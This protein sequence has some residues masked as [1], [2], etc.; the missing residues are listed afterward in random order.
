MTS[1]V[2]EQPTTTPPT[3]TG[4][5][6]GA[7]SDDVDLFCPGC[8]YHLRGIE[9]ID[10][11]PEC[12]L[13]I[14]RA[15]V[16][17]SLVPWAHRRHIGRFRAY[18]RTVWLATLHPRKLAA[19][20]AR[21]VEYRDA[22]RFRYVTAVL[23]AA[24][25]VVGM[26]VAM[27]AYGGSGFFSVVAPSAIPGWAMYGPPSPAVDVLVPWESGMTFYPVAPLA[28]LL[29]C[30][31]VTGV[32]TYWFHPKRL[33]VVR[34][35]RAIALAYYGCAPLALSPVPA[36]LFAAVAG[37]GI[38]G[39]NDPANAS[40]AVVRILSIALVLSTLAVVVL[41]WRTMMTLLN[42][43][44]QPGLGRLLLAGALIPFEWLVCAALALV[45]FPWVLGFFRLVIHSLR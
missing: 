16:A 32:H 6:D 18:W 24:P 42:R 15:G 19:E 33:P 17:R 26:V 2:D 12:G 1:T 22:R 37:M 38:A 31:L 40:W 44:T 11:C 23:A 14:D 29:L 45:A 30:V 5:S 10:R 35:N 13:A 8:G 20:S 25:V 43:A 28:V 39:L 4:L 41:T 3:A 7:V 27:I 9:G 34:Q 36:L 21:R